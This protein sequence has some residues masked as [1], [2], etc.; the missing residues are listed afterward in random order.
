MAEIK[1][2]PVKLITPSDCSLGK[3]STEDLQLIWR[4]KEAETRNKE[5]EVQAPCQG[6]GA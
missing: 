5:L 6:L 3:M 4:I 1:A 2:I